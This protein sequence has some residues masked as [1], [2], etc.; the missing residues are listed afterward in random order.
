MNCASL[1]VHNHTVAGLHKYV[2]MSSIQ[3][4]AYGVT[5]LCLY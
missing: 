4:L 3:Q 1:P 5:L 2:I